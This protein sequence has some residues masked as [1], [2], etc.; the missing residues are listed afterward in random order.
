MKIKS[1]VENLK[2]KQTNKKQEMI[3]KIKDMN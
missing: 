2:N 1:K 3:D